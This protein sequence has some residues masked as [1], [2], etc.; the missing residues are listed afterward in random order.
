MGDKSLAFVEKA[1]ELA[2]VN[3]QFAPSYFNLEELKIDLADASNLL[4]L[5]NRLQQFSRKI[6]DTAMLAGSEAFT[7]ALTFYNSVKQAARDNVPGA[8]PL[9]E[10]LKKRFVF[11]RPKKS[12]E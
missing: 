5:S 1:C 3:P 12:T 4:K 10:E 11:G 2:S 6:E 9:F 7:Q 8:Q